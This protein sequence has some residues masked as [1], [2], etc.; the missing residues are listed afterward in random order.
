LS[1]AIGGIKLMVYGEDL[2]KAI[3]II[4]GVE[5]GDGAMMNV[6]EDTDE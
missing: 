2:E 4:E 5:R 3:G 6:E 1:N